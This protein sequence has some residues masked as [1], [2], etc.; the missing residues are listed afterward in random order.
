MIT[1]R[2]LLT[3]MQSQATGCVGVV[4]F[5]T[6]G[7]AVTESC[8][9]DVATSPA[10]VARVMRELVSPRRLLLPDVPRAAGERV[11]AEAILLADDYT[12]VCRRV[13]DPPQHAVAAVCRGTRSLGLVAGL[14]RDAVVPGDAR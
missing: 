7:G 13:D 2:D 5:D 6:Q 10:G 9:D 12:Y 3:R 8:G 11:P 14:L 4:L 1:L